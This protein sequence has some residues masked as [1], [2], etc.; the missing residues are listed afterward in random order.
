MY[1][2]YGDRYL[3]SSAADWHEILHGG[4]YVS[5]PL[6]VAIS[7]GASKCRVKKGAQLGIFGPLRCLFFPFNCKYLKKIRCSITFQLGLN[8]SSTGA[9]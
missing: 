2:L 7:L 4:P 6:L 5:S 3:G 8:I 9:F 1:F